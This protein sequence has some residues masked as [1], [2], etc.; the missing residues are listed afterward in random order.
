MCNYQWIGWSGGVADGIVTLSRCYYHKNERR[1][2]K[3]DV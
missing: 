1:R 2:R 3:D